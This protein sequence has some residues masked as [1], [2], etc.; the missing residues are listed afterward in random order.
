MNPTQKN[1]A[2]QRMLKQKVMMLCYQMAALRNK[3]ISGTK[4]A[5]GLWWGQELQKMALIL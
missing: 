5:V 4:T 1:Q 3:Q 2:T